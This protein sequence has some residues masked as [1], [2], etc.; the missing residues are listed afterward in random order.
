MWWSG[1]G[2]FAVKVFGLSVAAEGGISLVLAVP[3][4]ILIL[5]FAYRLGAH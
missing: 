2:K 3:V 5:V 4:A 1:I